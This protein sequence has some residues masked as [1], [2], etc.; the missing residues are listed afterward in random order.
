MTWTVPC[1]IVVLFNNTEWR[2][3]ITTT[4]YQYLNKY[5]CPALAVAAL[6]LSGLPLVAPSS[7]L[8]AVTNR[9]SCFCHLVDNFS[10]RLLLFNLVSL[11]TFYS[12]IYSVVRN[13]ET[14]IPQLFVIILFYSCEP[15]FINSKKMCFL[16]FNCILCI[17]FLC[18]IHYFKDRV[19]N[20]KTVPL[21]A[22]E[23][24]GGVEV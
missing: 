24:L 21:H 16:L 11:N 5:V 22:M 3:S 7:P 14:L 18:C 8:S 13:K 4:L 6:Y 20:F 15:I 23:A 12:C 1:H 2:S 17:L 9:I 10:V 19:F